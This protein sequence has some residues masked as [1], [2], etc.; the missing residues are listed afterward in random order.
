[1]T[2]EDLEVGG[3]MLALGDSP[4]GAD[5]GRRTDRTLGDGDDV[6]RCRDLLVGGRI[7]ADDRE[8]GL[9]VGGQLDGRRLDGC[10]GSLGR[11]GRDSGHI[12]RAAAAA[13]EKHAEQQ[14]RQDGRSASKHKRASFWG[15]VLIIPYSAYLCQGNQQEFTIYP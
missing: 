5:L 9:A 4:V 6:G 8:V 13:E 1:M 7:G 12:R 11:G 15:V 14:S 2:D 3:D 10:G